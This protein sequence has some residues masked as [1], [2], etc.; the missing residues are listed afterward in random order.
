M[1]V[2]MMGPG[3]LKKLVAEW[4][5][6]DPAFVGL[7]SNAWCRRLKN[8]DPS[9]PGSYVYKFCFEY[10]PSMHSRRQQPP[11]HRLRLAG[12]AVSVQRAH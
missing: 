8:A 3:N 1:D 10:T 2:W 11:G 7:G 5:K 4:Y 9:E 6:E 12:T